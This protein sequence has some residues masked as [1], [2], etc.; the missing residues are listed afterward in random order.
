M[1]SKGDAALSLERGFIGQMLQ[2]SRTIWF[3]LYTTLATQLHIGVHTLT[4]HHSQ[5]QDGCHEQTDADGFRGAPNHS[6]ALDHLKTMGTG[7]KFICHSVLT[8]FI[9]DQ[10]PTADV[11]HRWTFEGQRA[12]RCT[13]FSLQSI[14]FPCTHELPRHSETIKLFKCLTTMP[15]TASGCNMIAILSALKLTANSFDQAQSNSCR[16]VCGGVCAFQSFMLH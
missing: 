16:C 5:S 9:G 8:T 1:K 10:N 4:L 6:S 15:L 13:A 2:V 3:R 12:F 7:V 11:I 14:A